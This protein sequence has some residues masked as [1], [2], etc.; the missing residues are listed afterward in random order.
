M[1]HT[2]LIMT[3]FLILVKR[4]IDWLWNKA[5][6]YPPT[7]PKYREQR[8]QTYSNLVSEFSELMHYLE[9]EKSIQLTL[10]DDSKI[11]RRFGDL[12]NIPQEMLE[13]MSLFLL[14]ELEIKILNVI[15]NDFNGIAGI[16]EIFLQIFRKHGKQL[17]RT[18]L[19]NKLNRMTKKGLVL[20]QEG[21]K[22]IYMIPE[23]S[24]KMQ[25]N[26]FEN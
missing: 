3:D 17:K 10:E 7:H 23:Y 25:E 26:Q 11:G 16:D 6:Q 9:R 12:S 4:Q 22:G 14:D 18:Y 20:P 15:T 24:Q 13:E 1:L 2:G 21:R 19:A 8:K 5:N